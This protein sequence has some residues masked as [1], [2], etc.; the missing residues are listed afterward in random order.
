MHSYTSRKQYRTAVDSGWGFFDNKNTMLER[1][2][3]DIC[4]L[5]IQYPLATTERSE[6][7]ITVRYEDHLGPTYTEFAYK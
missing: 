4:E 5:M 1:L 7:S 2:E 3:E 6:G